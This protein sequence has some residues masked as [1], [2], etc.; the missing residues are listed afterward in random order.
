LEYS[1]NGQRDGR[2]SRRWSPAVCVARFSLDGMHDAFQVDLGALNALV[3][4]SFLN[5]SMIVFL[6]CALLMFVVTVTEPRRKPGCREQA[7][8]GIGRGR[9]LGIRPGRSRVDRYGRVLRPQPVDSFQV[10][11]QSAKG[12]VS[13]RRTAK[14]LS[15]AAR[16]RPSTQDAAGCTTYPGIRRPARLRQ[17]SR[18]FFKKADM[19]SA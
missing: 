2:P 18:V 13:R 14:E 11:S 16:T 3:R 1:G 6:S 4:F 10:S 15:A 5:Y 17:W 9:K 19:R 8:D 12:A 7:D